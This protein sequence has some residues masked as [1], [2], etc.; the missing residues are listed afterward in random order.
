M[1]TIPI[2][3]GANALSST[4]RRYSVARGRATTTDFATPTG[5]ADNFRRRQL[6][7]SDFGVDRARL[8]P[9]PYTARGALLRS[10]TT[11]GALVPWIR[12]ERHLGDPAD[13]ACANSRSTASWLRRPGTTFAQKEWLDS[14][15]PA[16]RAR[17]SPRT[18]SGRTTAP[19][20]PRRSFAAGS[21]RSTRT[22]RSPPARRDGDGPWSRATEP[23][24]G[25]VAYAVLRTRARLGHDWAR[26]RASA[27]DRRRSLLDKVQ[28]K[29]TTG[30]TR[31]TTSP[32][33]T[34]SRPLRRGVVSRRRQAR[35]QLRELAGGEHPE[36][37][38]PDARE[39]ARR[40]FRRD[41][42]V[43]RL[44]ADLLARLGRLR[45][46]VPPDPRLRPRR[47][48]EE[49][50]DG[51]GLPHGGHEHRPDLAD[52]AGLRAAVRLGPRD[53]AGRRRGDRLGQGR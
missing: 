36:R 34:R 25:S 2:A 42:P 52:A 4:C 6:Q 8:P 1:H 17:S 30:T 16:T 29:G 28:S 11:C 40:H 43:R 38:R 45:A 13:T 47:R 23:I 33:R 3:V 50:A 15:D 41:R 7:F 21:R 51:Q 22:G 44:H 39:L 31:S 5:P 14:I 32:I 27:G 18:P 37:Q 24:D 53:R 48:G 12:R 46:P 9:D 10:I 35:R 19:T 26:F 49:G 20:A